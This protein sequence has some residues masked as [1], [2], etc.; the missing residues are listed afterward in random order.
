MPRYPRLTD[1]VE[2]W[3]GLEDPLDE[4]QELELR[5]RTVHDHPVPGQSEQPSGRWLWWVLVLVACLVLGC[6]S[7]LVA[8]RLTGHRVG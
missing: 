6:L 5:P 8:L 7:F 2:E 1:K 3:L 4:R